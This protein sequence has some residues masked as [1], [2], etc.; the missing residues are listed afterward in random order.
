ME[1]LEQPTCGHHGDSLN[2]EC[3]ACVAAERD[4]YRQALI[5]LD[6]R[7]AASDPDIGPGWTGIPPLRRMIDAALG[8]TL[9]K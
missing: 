1:H 4:R 8:R 6:E 7:M 3:I 2:G 5:D 9:I